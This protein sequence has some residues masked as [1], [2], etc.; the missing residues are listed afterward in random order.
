MPS[1]LAEQL[2]KEELQKYVTLLEK[3]QLS[4]HDVFEE[5]KEFQ[6]RHPTLPEA[7]NLLTYLYIRKRNLKKV[8][9]LILECYEKFPHYLFARINYADLCLRKRKFKKIPEIFSS[10]NLADLYP[11]KEIFH[12]TEVRGFM[13]TLGFYHH[14]MNKKN[15]AREC[16]E[17][18][19]EVDPDHPSVELLEKKLR[20]NLLKRLL[21]IGKK[22]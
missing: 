19:K 9:E 17:Q 20:P 11:E 1:S 10:F 15:E 12:Y 13:V 5:V 3:A 8:D 4:P 2:S 18:A 14:S 22:K 7:L 16:L 21:R 6:K